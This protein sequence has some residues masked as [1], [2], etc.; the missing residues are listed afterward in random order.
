MMVPVTFGFQ[1]QVEFCRNISKYAKIALFR[2]LPLTFDTNFTGLTSA[3][4][5]RTLGPNYYKKLEL[6]A[7]EALAAFTILMPTSSPC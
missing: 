4:L 1:F 5:N 2:Y 7:P 3:D 6:Q